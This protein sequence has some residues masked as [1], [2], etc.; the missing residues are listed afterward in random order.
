MPHISSETPVGTP[1]ELRVLN[2]VL[3][4]WGTCAPPQA[5]FGKGCS[6][7]HAC[8]FARPENGGFRDRGPHNVGVLKSN[9]ETGV[10]RE[11]VIEC[12]TY[13][14]SMHQYNRAE[15]SVLRFAVIAQEGETIEVDETVPI[16]ANSNKSGNVKMKL[17][18]RKVVIPAF[19]RPGMPGS[20]IEPGSVRAQSAL[21][22]HAER[23]VQMRQDD[24]LARSIARPALPEVAPESLFAAASPTDQVAGALPPP[25]IIPR[26]RGRPPKP[27]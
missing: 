20:K 15:N 26:K 27:R 6:E 25:P 16:D 1:D 17:E 14:R 8:I 24:E 18:P 2:K 22:R 5:G 10:A 13:M 11:D 3:A 23:I 21:R 9:S 4:D 19:P 7:Y 12:H